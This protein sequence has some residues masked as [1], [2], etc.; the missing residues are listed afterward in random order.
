[1]K[2]S[3][4][5]LWLIPTHVNARADRSIMLAPSKTA[6][7]AREVTVEAL[8]CRLRLLVLIVAAGAIRKITCH[9][10][11]VLV[12]ASFLVCRLKGKCDAAHAEAAEFG[13]H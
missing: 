12:S 4:A 8:S 11:V 3:V 9:F 1:M 7:L 5:L 6:H 13:L 10:S 2:P